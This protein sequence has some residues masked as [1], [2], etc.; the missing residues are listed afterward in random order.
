ML[1]LDDGATGPGSAGRRAARSGDRLVTIA[2]RRG[3]RSAAS[4][5]RPARRALL[6]V[7]DETAVPAVCS[8]LEDLPADARGT[9]FLEVPVTGDVLD[10]APRPGVEV[11]WLPRDGAPLGERGCTRRWWPTWAQPVE[12]G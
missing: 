5:S 11:V 12:R 3:S 6:L 8:I 2:P 9:A 4:S 10:L 7:G 1:H